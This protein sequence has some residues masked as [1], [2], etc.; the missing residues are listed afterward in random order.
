[1]DSEE[2]LRML[3]NVKASMVEDS[4][5]RNR[6]F[7]RRLHGHGN[8][9]HQMLKILVDAELGQKPTPNYPNKRT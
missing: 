4:L 9:V 1:M 3:D 8:V 7:V 6:V 2:L 5:R